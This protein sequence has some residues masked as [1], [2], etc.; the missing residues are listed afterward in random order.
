MFDVTEML[1]LGDIAD[2]FL[3][4][5]LLLS[6]VCACSSIVQLYISEAENC[7]LQSCKLRH[8]IVIGY[9]RVEVAYI[10]FDENFFHFCF[11]CL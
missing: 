10:E 7:Y 9:C 3:H 5:S 2:I 11:L 6:D 8:L 4:L 1:V